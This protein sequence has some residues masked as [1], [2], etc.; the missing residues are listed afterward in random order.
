[1]EAVAA[2]GEDVVRKLHIDQVVTKA[3]KLPAPATFERVGDKVMCPFGCGGSLAV[4]A[5]TGVEHT[6]P[7]SPLSHVCSRPE[8]ADEG[9][10]PAEAWFR[11]LS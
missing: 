9:G 5:L 6:R 4:A 1:M 3:A 7:P 8:G 11:R 10:K 2:A